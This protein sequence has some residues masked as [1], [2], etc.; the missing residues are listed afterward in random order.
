MKE[1]Q[2]LHPLQHVANFARPYL[3]PY[4]C[5]DGVVKGYPIPSFLNSIGISI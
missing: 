2:K 4:G 5:L 3:Y 1:K